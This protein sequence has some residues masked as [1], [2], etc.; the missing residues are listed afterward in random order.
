MSAHMSDR[1]SSPRSDRG[2]HP[3]RAPASLVAGGEAGD[4]GGKPAPHASI[5]AVARKHGI[6]TGQLYGWRHQLLGDRRNEVRASP[7]SS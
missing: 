7:A 6:G 3:R 5:M 1:M 4:R 2:D